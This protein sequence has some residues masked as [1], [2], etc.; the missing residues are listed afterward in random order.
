MDR[1]TDTHIYFWGSIFSNWANTPFEYKG[2]EFS[3]SEQAF[4]W[5]KAVFFED[6]EIA[7]AIL[8]NNNP[9][10]VKALGKKVKGFNADTWM[11]K[12]YEVMVDVCFAKFQQNTT[13]TEILLSTN[14]KIIVEASPHDKIWGIGLHWNDDRVLNENTWQ[15]LN[16]LGKALME[17]REKIKESYENT[18]T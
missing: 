1:I 2:K 12:G 16:L 4:M 8:E 10:T 6:K 18:I 11:K 17:V 13:H 14:D 5:E 3:N 9:S 7:D 15:G